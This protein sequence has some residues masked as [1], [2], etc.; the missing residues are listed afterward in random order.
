[1]KLMNTHFIAGL[2]GIFTFSL[3]LIS[4]EGRAENCSAPLPKV[5]QKEWRSSFPLAP[6]AG[7]PNHRIRDMILPK[8]YTQATLRARFTYGQF[9]KDLEEE[10]VQAWLLRCPDWQ[11]LGT[12][13]TSDEGV[14]KVPAPTNLAPGDYAVRFV[15]LGDRSE[16]RGTISVWPPG[17]QIVVSDIDGTLTT[18]DWEAVDEVVEILNADSAKMYP[19]AN[20]VLQ[21]WAQKGYRIVYLSGRLQY[22][23]RYTHTWLDRHNFPAGPV[24]LTARKRQIA[25]IRTGVQKFKAE[26]LND[27]TNRVKVQIVAAYGNAPTDIG[28]YNDAGI[29][30]DKTF[31]IGPHA[32]EHNTGKI[33]S[34]TDHLPSINAQPEALNADQ[35]KADKDTGNR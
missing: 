1:M 11:L 6:L 31:I 34:Y 18:S 7:K 5:E 29:P 28:A 14:V 32:G 21:A 30:K 13:E 9:D 22:V 15:V 8:D 23:N 2:V 27:L 24:I 3:C 17:T 12:F 4:A 16:A 10:Q 35:K 26:F 19:D 20:T 25:P 33:G